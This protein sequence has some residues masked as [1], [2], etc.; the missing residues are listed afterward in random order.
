MMHDENDLLI[1]LDDDDDLA[2]L[3]AAAEVGRLVLGRSIMNG[4]PKVAIASD[5]ISMKAAW[6]PTP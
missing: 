1:M 6:N 3:R 4:L 2:V 5:V